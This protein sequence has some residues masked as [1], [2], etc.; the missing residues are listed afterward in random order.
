MLLTYSLLVLTGACYTSV[1]C[2]R[3]DRQRKTET[4]READS[5]RNIHK[6]TDRQINRERGGGGD[7]DRQIQRDRQTD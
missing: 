2:R 7:R 1:V 6:Q 5:D 4:D 3:E